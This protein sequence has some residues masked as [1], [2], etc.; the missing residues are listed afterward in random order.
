M[1]K[2]DFFCGFPEA[3]K[4]IEFL[5]RVQVCSDRH[6]G[7]FPPPAAPYDLSLSSKYF[8]SKAVWRDLRMCTS[9]GLRI[10]L[11]IIR[12]QKNRSDLQ[13]NLEL[14][15]EKNRILPNFDLTIF[16]LYIFLKGSNLI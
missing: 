11:D 3:N 12:N 13:K 6:A 7:I 4:N 8:F 15:F 2:K 1:V 10:R 5:K 9:Q 16:T 14:A